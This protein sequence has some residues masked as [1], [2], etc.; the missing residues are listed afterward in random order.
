MSH[1]T[2]K[3]SLPLGSACRLLQGHPSMCFV[4][5]KAFC[6]SDFLMKSKPT[7]IL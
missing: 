2:S 3:V 5:L 6:D 1:V 7:R 4:H